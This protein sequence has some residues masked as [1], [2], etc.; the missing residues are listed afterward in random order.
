M[1]NLCYNAI[2]GDPRELYALLSEDFELDFNRW[3]PMPESL[4]QCESG[5]V[6]ELVDLGCAQES[7]SDGR[8]LA[9]PA[10]KLLAAGKR[11]L[12]RYREALPKDAY[13]HFWPEAADSP[14]PPTAAY[15]RRGGRTYLVTEPAQLRDL[16]ATLAANVQACGSPTWYDWRIRNWGV[17]WNAGL[18]HVEEASG[19]GVLRFVTPWAEPSAQLMGAILADCPSAIAAEAAYEDFDGT[20]VDLMEQKARDIA[21]SVAFER[22]VVEGE[23]AGED[24][25]TFQ[26]RPAEDIAALLG[27]P[28]R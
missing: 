15:L 21:E 19:L 1:P 5:Y 26:E 20:F 6:S 8:L 22:L 23:A 7:L 3:V 25:E 16:A 10:A 4:S 18:A 13:G 2:V 24:W 14:D 17:K 12:A 11:V 28:Q 27:A 9:H